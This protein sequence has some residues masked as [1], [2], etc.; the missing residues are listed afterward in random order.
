MEGLNETKW[1][2]LCPG[3]G[4]DETHDSETSKRLT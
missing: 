2:K 1:S 3:G 4:H